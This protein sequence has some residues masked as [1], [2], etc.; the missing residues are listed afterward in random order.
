MTSNQRLDDKGFGP[1][2]KIC[3]QGSTFTVRFDSLEAQGWAPSLYAFKVGGK[4]LRIGK[5]EGPLLCRMHQW[6]RL[7]SQALAG[8]FTLGG[9]NPWEAFKWREYLTQAG[10]GE[11][12]AREVKQEEVRT[13][14]REL[15]RHYDPQL[16]NDSPCA[17]QRPPEQRRVRDVR[18]AEAYWRRLNKRTQSPE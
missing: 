15:I 7:V 4:V 3:L 1:V 6:E 9:T 10:S 14:E 18:E 2:G 11:F 5:S 13:L 16:C 8:K 17:R 12:L